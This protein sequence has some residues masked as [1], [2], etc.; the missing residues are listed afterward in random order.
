[1]EIDELDDD[2]IQITCL[3]GAKTTAPTLRGDNPMEVVVT[4]HSA[5]TAV[6]F[7]GFTLSSSNKLIGSF[8]LSFFSIWIL[9]MA[10]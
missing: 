8:F 10:F 4:D 1:M 5:R 7:E 2:R 3:I 9:Y 6:Q